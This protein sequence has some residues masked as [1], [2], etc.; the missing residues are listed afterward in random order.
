MILSYR[1]VP[2]DEVEACK[3]DM[4]EY[5]G[6][7]YVQFTTVDAENGH[8]PVR[9]LQ[10]KLFSYTDLHALIVDSVASHMHAEAGVLNR[11]ITMVDR[12]SGDHVIINSHK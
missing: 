5:L 9:T 8:N 11:L 3:R 4:R 6:L 10:W 12:G 7:E 2:C 1:I